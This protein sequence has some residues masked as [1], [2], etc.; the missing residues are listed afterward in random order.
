MKKEYLKKWANRIVENF[1]KKREIS[2]NELIQFVY[3]AR[4]SL[5]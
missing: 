5:R 3:N 4:E 1:E 2:V